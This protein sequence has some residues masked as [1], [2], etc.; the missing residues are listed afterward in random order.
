MLLFLESGEYHSKQV[1]YQFM[2]YVLHWCSNINR[3]PRHNKPSFWSLVDLTSATYSRHFHNSMP[4]LTKK[5]KKEE[6]KQERKCVHVQDHLS[7]KNSHTRVTQ[8]LCTRSWAL[9]LAFPQ[10]NSTSPALSEDV[11]LR[12]ILWTAP[13]F[14]NRTSGLGCRASPFKL[15]TGDMDTGAESSHWKQASSGAETSTSSSSLTTVRDWAAPGENRYQTTLQLQW[16]MAKVN[17]L[18]NKMK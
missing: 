9:L 11:C 10:V 7:G 4:G 16:M 14:S 3:Q 1:K 5:K 18:K 12:V 15:H 13:V 6:R 8:W 17:Y 2:H